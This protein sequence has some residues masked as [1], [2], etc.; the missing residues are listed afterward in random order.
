MLLNLG[1]VDVPY[2][3]QPPARGRRKKRGGGAARITTGDVADI[4]EGRYHVMEHFA[5]IHQADVAAALEDGL[6]GALETLMMGGSPAASLFATAEGEIEESFKRM[7][8]TKELDRLGYPGVPTQA[9]LD[10]R[11]SR[12]KRRR[13]PARPSFVDTGLYVGSFKAWVEP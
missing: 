4:L 3:H 13:G 2:A 12:F 7:I 9:S 6:A 8:E 5:Q 1:V 10:G 11:S